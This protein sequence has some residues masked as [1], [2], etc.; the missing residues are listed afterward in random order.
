[1]ILTT[2]LTSK[3]STVSDRITRTIWIFSSQITG[4]S[5][6]SL[7]SLSSTMR[8]Y[9]SRRGAEGNAALFSSVKLNQ[10]F[11]NVPH[12]Y[13]YAFR[14]HTFPCTFD[15]KHKSFG[16]RSGIREILQTYPRFS[17]ENNTEPSEAQ[18][19]IPASRLAIDVNYQRSFEEPST[20]TF[21][22]YSLD[23]GPIR[24]KLGS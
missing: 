10:R 13:F 8:N 2:E 21:R 3:Q 20:V 15:E 5:T 4:T 12:A 9:A 17:S 18:I 23:S 7:V 1:M 16:R 11:L 19:E 14:A 6:P 22:R 24:P